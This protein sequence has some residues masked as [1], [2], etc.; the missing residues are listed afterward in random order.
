[1]MNIRRLELTDSTNS[2]VARSHREFGVATLVYAV[3]QTAGRGQ[4][5]NSWESEPGKNLTFS[6]FYPW[7][8]AFPASRQFAVS[9]AVALSIVD[10]LARE[11]IAAV[12]KWP[13]DIYVGDRKICGILIQHSVAGNGL[14]HSVIG[15]GLNIN[16]LV[17]R[18]DAPNP[19]SMAMIA[20]REWLPDNLVPVIADMLAERLEKA[21]TERGREELHREFLEKL[22][23]GDGQAYPFRD[24]ARNVCYE[25][26]IEDVEAG[27]TLCI[28]SV[29]GDLYRYAFKEVEF[30]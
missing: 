3:E 27:G 11:G 29:E 4:R 6:L 21:K 5:G 26:V 18:S 23:R 28:K 10:L 19:V 13:N 12:A 1:M 20:G 9:E 14:E 8:E 7:R 15:V 30:L 22:W 25:G 16:Q 17:F 24:V 2:Y